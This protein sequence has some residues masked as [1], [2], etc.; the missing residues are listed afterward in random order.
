[1]QCG[2]KHSCCRYATKSYLS[3]RSSWVVPGPE[4][5]S[6]PGGFVCVVLWGCVAPGTP[7]FGM[8][9]VLLCSS[10]AWVSASG[11]RKSKAG[12]CCQQNRSKWVEIFSVGLQLMIIFIIDISGNNFYN[13][14]EKCYKCSSQQPK[15]QRLLI[16]FHKWLRKAAN[17][18]I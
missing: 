5:L 9:L 11:P 1:M 16:Y 10:W 6:S 15:T 7:G 2:Y 3:S 14:S 13:W 8:K 17:S 18:H 4:S 12:W